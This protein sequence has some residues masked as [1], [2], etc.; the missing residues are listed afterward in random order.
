[1]PTEN[2]SLCERVK[3]ITFELTH[4]TPLKAR[5]NYAR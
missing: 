3:S 5:A 4:V 2:L 1:M